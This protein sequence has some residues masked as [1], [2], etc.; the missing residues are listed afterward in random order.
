M[1][2][3]HILIVNTCIRRR[4]CSPSK[5]CEQ[6]LLNQTQGKACHLQINSCLPLGSYSEV[7]CIARNLFNMITYLGAGIFN[8]ELELLV[9]DRCSVA[10]RVAGGIFLAASERL[11]AHLNAAV[12][13]GLPG[14]TPHRQISGLQQCHLHKGSS[15]LWHHHHTE[16]QC[17]LPLFRDVGNTAVS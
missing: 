14:E 15:M 9:P 8:K 7:S 5:L 2:A 17:M 13:I 11:R 10:A 6:V 4:A 3:S 16:A 12:W 1:W